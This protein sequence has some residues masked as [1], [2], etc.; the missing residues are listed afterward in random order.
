MLKHVLGLENRDELLDF[1]D[2]D[3]RWVEPVYTGKDLIS[4]DGLTKKDIW[5]TGYSKVNN[6]GFEYWEADSFPLEGETD[7]YALE[8]FNWPTTDLFDFNSLRSQIRK[9]KGYAIMTAPGYSSPGLFRIIQRLLGR[10]TF[11]DVITYHP[12]FFARLA[13]KIS[14]FYLDYIDRFF[15][16]ANGNVDFI[17]IAD[18][19]GSDLGLNISKDIWEEDVKPVIQSFVE[20]P[21]SHGV[22]F[23][24]HSCGS[25]RKLLPE[26]ISIGVDV[27]DPIQIDAMGMEPSGLKE[28][29]GPYIT[30]SGALDEKLLMKKGAEDKVKDGVKKLLDIM[31]PGGGFILGPSHKIK[32]ETPV[33]NVI[34]MY[35]AAK[36]WKY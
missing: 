23:Y 24:M 22:K 12:K 2:V 29:F 7:P 5:G 13:K 31:A 4:N 8:D 9:Y 33:E 15:E 34:A 25:V 20:V 11:L 28:Y 26:F 30:F 3:F 1:L 19:F 17:R 35:E 32:H 16:K 14:E 10:D 27:L 36:E 6:G 21:L 18:D